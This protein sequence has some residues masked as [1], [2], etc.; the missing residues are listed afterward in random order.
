MTGFVPGLPSLEAAIAV[1]AD[2]VLGRSPVRV[3]DLGGGPG[4]LAERM[5]ARWPEAAVT[6]IDIDPVLLA[7]ARDGVPPAVSVIDADLGEAL[8]IND[9]SI[10]AD[11]SKLLAEGDTVPDDVLRSGALLGDALPNGAPSGGARS[12]GALPNGALP[13]GALPNGALPNGALPNGALPDGALPDGPR[14]DGAR[15][16]GA[17]PADRGYDLA[18]AVMTV[19]YLRPERIRALYRRCRRALAPGGL[20]VVADLM[21]DD[22]LPSVMS[23]LNPAPGEAAAELAWAQWWGEVGEASEF[24]GLME[25]RADVFRSRPPANFAGSVSWHVAAARSAGF[26]EAGL[27][28]RDGRHAAMAAVA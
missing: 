22:G 10:Q 3:L 23:A 8:P 11:D 5:S 15:S 1:A 17:L 19:H 7:L 24:A 27:L 6:M 13:D 2:A 26:R 20:L 4:V 18:T 16:H 21:P 9:D 14:S 25:S 12:G 28:W